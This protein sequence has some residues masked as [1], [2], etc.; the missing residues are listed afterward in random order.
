[1]VAGRFFA[2]HG[3]GVA[4]GEGVAVT[5]GADLNAPHAAMK[6]KET[7][8]VNSNVAFLIIIL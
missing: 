8:A 4:D 3:S 5:L 7:V 2:L 6:S 1:M